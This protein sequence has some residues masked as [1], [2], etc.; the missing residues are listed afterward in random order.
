MHWA[1][2][3]TTV[4]S[5]RSPSSTVGTFQG[6]RHRFTVG[7]GPSLPDRAPLSRSMSRRPSTISSV[8]AQAARSSTFETLGHASAPLTRS[9][10]AIEPIEASSLQ[11]VGQ[12]AAV[13]GPACTLLD[14]QRVA[15]LLDA[16]L[17]RGP[18]Q[19]LPCPASANRS[20]RRQSRCAPR[21][22]ACERPSTGKSRPSAR[23][24]HGE[25]RP[26][27]MESGSRILDR[28]H[29]GRDIQVHVFEHQHRVLAARARR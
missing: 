8:R 23:G 6:E 2:N 26:C 18:V 20:P 12:P 5:S 28:G 15:G 22:R 11:L 4:S 24:R 29:P 25:P 13:R 9:H 17:D 19:R 16:C 3:P 1:A 21:P 10:R 7:A 27:R 14:N